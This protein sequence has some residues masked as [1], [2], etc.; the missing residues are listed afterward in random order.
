MR[1]VL[2]LA[3]MLGFVLSVA[4][5]NSCTD[6]GCISALIVD[7]GMDPSSSATVCVDGQCATTTEVPSEG[8]SG[9]GVL[10]AVSDGLAFQPDW[11]LSAGDHDVTITISHPNREGV[12]FADTIEFT[13]DDCNPTCMTARI[14][15]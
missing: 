13:P 4:G 7:V 15:F 8:S 1:P 9:S 3:L 6:E 11:E 12:D 10:Q 2:L 14:G 5:C